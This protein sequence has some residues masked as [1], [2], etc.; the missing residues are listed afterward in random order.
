M[1]KEVFM[2]G[3]TILWDDDGYRYRVFLDQESGCQ[4]VY[5]EERDAA[6][7]EVD[8]IGL[9]F[10]SSVDAM[11]KALTHVKSLMEKQQ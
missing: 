3:E 7:V 6:M 11:I 4:I 5:E 10:A 8:R 1:I 2:T 9:P